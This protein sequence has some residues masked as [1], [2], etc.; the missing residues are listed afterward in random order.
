MNERKNDR[1]LGFL[2]SDLATKHLELI[3][4]V[5]QFQH[6]FQNKLILGLKHIGLRTKSGQYKGT[7]R[8]DLTNFKMRTT[9]KVKTPLKM[10]TETHSRNKDKPKNEDNPN[11][12]DNPENEDGLKK[13]G[14]PKNG[15]FLKN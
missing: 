10:K 5:G 8:G 12:H 1:I 11:D 13:E 4:F 3:I 2:L 7:N 6:K 14:D 15:D 9:I